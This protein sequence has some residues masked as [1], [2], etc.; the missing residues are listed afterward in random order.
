M[1]ARQALM[2]RMNSPRSM[3]GTTNRLPRLDF[4]SRINR[5]SPI[6]CSGSGMVVESQ[7]ANAVRASSNETPCFFRFSRAFFRSHS[8]FTSAVYS[9]VII[10]AT[11][12]TAK[13]LVSNRLRTTTPA[14]N[15]RDHASRRTHADMVNQRRRSPVRADYH[16]DW[17]AIGRGSSCRTTP[18]KVPVTSRSTTYPRPLIRRRTVCDAAERFLW[19][20]NA[21]E[22]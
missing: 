12:R 6:E 13:W 2:I 4:P 9:S 1:L 22:C 17:V 8:N 14:T 20:R 18:C 10:S 7:S 3:C 5:S 19:R 21:R 11:Y 15:H 16:T